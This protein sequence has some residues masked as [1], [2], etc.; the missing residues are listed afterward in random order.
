MKPARRYW[1]LALV[2]LLQFSFL[3]GGSA[4]AASQS[5][6][7]SA[8][9]AI[10]DAFAATYSAAQDGG[11]VSALVASLNLA[12][13]LVQDAEAVNSTSP[14]LAQSY[15]SNASEIAQQV[16]QEAPGVAQSGANA[17]A[18]QTYESVGAALLIVIVAAALYLFGGR[19]YRRGWYS[20]YK[21]FTVGVRHE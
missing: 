7:S 19:V 12:L 3:S 21:G 9:S 11:N 1:A 15:L 20:L 2:V 4:T 10:G 16:A 18:L 13:G 14:A 6:F 5:D 17:R 8:R